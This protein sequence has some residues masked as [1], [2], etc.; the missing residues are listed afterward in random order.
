MVHRSM[1]AGTTLLGLVIACGASSESGV[2]ASDP[3]TTPC[4]EVT[5][6]EECPATWAQT[7][8]AGKDYCAAHRGHSEFSLVRSTAACGP[9]LRYS[10]YLFDAGPRNCLYDPKT[11]KLV[12]Y[13]FFDG[14]ASWQK[15]T[16]NVEQGEATFPQGCARVTCVDPAL[17]GTGDAGH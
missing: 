6:T 3:T 12:G 7:I 1:L 14:K 13:A 8:T 17:G 9:W 5:P 2:K 16:C 15:R 4:V 10:L 11:E